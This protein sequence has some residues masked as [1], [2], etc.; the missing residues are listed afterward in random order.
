MIRKGRLVLC[1]AVLF[2]LQVTVVHRFTHAFLRPDLLFLAAA[3]LAL[4]ADF[5]GALWSAF[6][7]GLLRDL[8]SGGR[9][10]ASAI[11]LVAASAVLVTVRRRLMRESFWPDMVLTFAY[12]LACGVVSALAVWALSEAGQL[13]ELLARAA[14]QA[15]F[16]TAL[17]PLVFV[18]FSKLG[19]VDKDLALLDAT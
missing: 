19:L 2:L 3:F 15:A 5:T 17:S 1:V 11:V 7:L 10:G 6:A 13:R 18:A 8:G 4:E 12:V 9:I 14:G 16:T